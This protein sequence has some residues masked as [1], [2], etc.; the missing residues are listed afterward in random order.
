MERFQNLSL[1]LIIR[2]Q[3]TNPELNIIT[4]RIIQLLKVLSILSIQ[5]ILT[6]TRHSSKCWLL[7]F[8][9]IWT[10]WTNL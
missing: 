10:K 2:S 4:H 3:F 1:T 6:V 5:V 7:Y 8:K 9:F